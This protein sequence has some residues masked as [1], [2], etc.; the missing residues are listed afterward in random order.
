M[1]LSVTSTLTMSN[2]CRQAA[3]SRGGGRVE[4]RFDFS[5]KP[6]VVEL[7]SHFLFIPLP[8]VAL[9]VVNFLARSPII[10]HAQVIE[11]IVQE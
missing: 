9:L 10:S 3:A 1:G 8:C 7:S 4:L 6:S 11:R 2:Y 5:F